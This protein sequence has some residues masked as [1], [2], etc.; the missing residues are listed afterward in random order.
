M[1][2]KILYT[3]ITFACAITIVACGSEPVRTESEVVSVTT[4][5]SQEETEKMQEQDNNEQGSE[6]ETA[7]MSQDEVMAQLEKD[8]KWQLEP[9]DRVEN[10]VLDDNE[11]KIDIY[12]TKNNVTIKR[13]EGISEAVLATE[14]IYDQWETLIVDFGS[15]GCIV[16][17]KDDV[18]YDG[19][20]K[21]FEVAKEDIIEPMEE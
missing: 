21:Y 2:K 9:R 13:Y 4:N 5:N 7:E 12:L 8:V 18:L 6:D 19:E 1:K 3:I 16:K 14:E 17:T 10:I 20:K 15:L 11:L